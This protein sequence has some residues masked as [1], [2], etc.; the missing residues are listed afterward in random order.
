MIENNTPFRTIKTT[1]EAD[2]TKIDPN[3]PKRGEIQALGIPD[4]V[5]DTGTENPTEFVSKIG[6]FEAGLGTPGQLHEFVEEAKEVDRLKKKIQGSGVYGM[7]DPVDIAK[8]V[9]DNATDLTSLTFDAIDFSKFTTAD[10]RLNFVASC[11][12]NAG[13]NHVGLLGEM[14]S[15]DLMSICKEAGSSDL[16]KVLML[17]IIKRRDVVRQMAV[18][19]DA[20]LADV[21]IAA[22]E[23]FIEQYSAYK[24]E[25]G[26]EDQLTDDE[27]T[28]AKTVLETKKKEK[29]AQIAR[30]AAK[31]QTSVPLIGKSNLRERY[32]KAVNEDTDVEQSQTTAQR[33]E[34]ITTEQERKARE[35]LQFLFADVTAK[36]LTFDEARA[37]INRWDVSQGVKD[38]A[39]ARLN[40]HERN[41][42]TEAAKK[43]F[44]ETKAKY[45]SGTAKLSDIEAMIN[46]EPADSQL[47]RMLSDLISGEQEAMT[48]A[49]QLGEFNLTNAENEANRILGGRQDQTPEVR[50]DMVM[51]QIQRTDAWRDLPEGVQK[52]LDERWKSVGVKQSQLRLADSAKMEAANLRMDSET[53]KHNWESIKITLTRVAKWLGVSSAG[54]AM[55]LLVPGGWGILLAAGSLAGMGLYEKYDPKTKETIAKLAD[56]KGDIATK[57]AALEELRRAGL[58]RSIETYR[59]LNDLGI[60]L[61]SGGD[62]KI[63]ERLKKASGIGL[64]NSALGTFATTPTLS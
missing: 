30:G 48:T 6:V 15:T 1:G 9:E 5:T 24:N 28:K 13:G 40:G 55:V 20:P 37:Q 22:L 61:V 12:R 33:P 54:L 52:I 3:T 64:M 62:A 34:K 47:R 7:E 31:A 25:L 23:K 32:Q 51:D 63:A 43:K 49:K 27:I 35:R 36:M 21:S 42:K 26:D 14:D 46:S 57:Q 29:N 2:Y 39:L 19:G 8:Y 45:E 38:F 17:E 56:M 50:N 16:G 44:D 53:L 11:L 58:D 59:R 18:V 4:L 10:A 60:Q 41:E